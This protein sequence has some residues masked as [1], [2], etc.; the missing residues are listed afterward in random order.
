M[1]KNFSF[2][3]GF[4]VLKFFDVFVLFFFGFV[5]VDVLYFI[6]FIENIKKDNGVSKVILMKCNNIF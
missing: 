3:C 1:L 2:V 5:V 4:I 6:W